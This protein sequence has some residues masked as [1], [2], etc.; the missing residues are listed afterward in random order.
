MNKTLFKFV[1]FVVT[2]LA[3]VLCLA[4]C[5]QAFSNG[6]QSHTH[7]YGKWSSDTA[8]CYEGGLKVRVCS[9]CDEVET[10]KTQPL[11]HDMQ[12]CDD[13][14]AGCLEGGYTNCKQCSRCE[15]FEGESTPPAGHD[16][17]E[18]SVTVEA[19]CESDGTATRTCNRCGEPET[20]KTN[21]LGHDMIKFE[22]VKVSCLEDGYSN[23]R[24]CSRCDHHEGTK[25]N[26]IGHDMSEWFGNTATCTKD[27]IEFSEC[28]RCDYDEERP[29]TAKGHI[30]EGDYCSRCQMDRILVLIENGVANFRVVHTANS[31]S[32]GAILADMFVERLRELGVTV[33]DSVLDVDNVGA[34]DCEIIIGAEAAGRGDECKITAHY[35][36]REGEVIKRVGNKIIIAATDSSMTQA[37][38][39]KFVSECLGITAQTTSLDYLEINETC[40]YENIIKFPISDIFINS[41][42]IDRYE[43]VLDLATDMHKDDFSAIYSF[44]D[45]LR[46]VSGYRL[47]SATALGMQSNKNYIV[48]RYTNDAGEDGFRVYVDGNKFVIECAYKNVFDATF[49]E[50]ANNYFLNA[51]GDINIDRDFRYAKTVSKVYYEDFGAVGDGE[52]CDFEAIYNAHVFANAGGQ[53][54]FGKKDAVYYISPDKFNKSIPIKTN[55]DFCGA[56]FIVND[57]GSSAYSSRSKPLF[58]IERDYEYRSVSTSDI[59]RLTGSN[60]ISIPE[61]TTSIK[62]LVPELE[63]KSM[64]EII[65]THRDYIRHGANQNNG[66]QRTDMVIINPDG[67][68]DENTYVAYDFESVTLIRIYR[69][70]ENPL[71]VENG[72]FKNICCKVIEDTY[73]DMPVKNEDGSEGTVRMY[74]ANKYHS[75]KRGFGIYRSNVTIKNITHEMLDE[76]DLGWYPEE[77]GYSPDAKYYDKY[78][79]IAYGS[80]HESY[81]YYGFLFVD[82]AYNLQVIDTVLDGH[83]TYYEDKPATLSTGNEIPEPVPMG[84]YDFVLEYSN[85]VTFKNVQQRDESGI[86][87]SRYWGIMSSNGSRNLTFENCKINRFDAHRGFWN[88]TLINTTIGHSFNVVGGGT[89]IADGV[90]KITGTTFI[91]L[92]GDYGATFKGDMILK[93]CVFENHPSYNTSK[94]SSYKD[95]QNNE[96]YIINSGFNVKNSGWSEKNI[97]GAYWLWDFGYTC[98]MPQNITLDNFTSCA[99]KKTYLFNDL[100]DII[101]E[102]TYTE[103]AEITKAT[104][105]YPYQITQNITY[106]G[107]NQFEMCKGTTKASSSEFGTFTYQKLNSIPV[108]KDVDKNGKCDVCDD[109]SIKD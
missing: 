69:V 64:L 24:E 35:L 75:Y 25:I 97:F 10:K 37:L 84:S 62:W 82:R 16:M 89:L 19:K 79:N 52:T 14:A 48:I 38:F 15:L 45:N 96:A 29:T 2:S 36:G 13:I 108:H 41:V 105:K 32:T 83:T 65:S 74:Y 34:F 81:P 20:K 78:G 71:T 6:I 66:N 55:V 43:L 76:P 18:W 50:F 67:T 80:R 92:R 7:E 53:K 86:G 72:N 1:I 59:E 42:S 85:Y 91:S 21:A 49:E 103:G 3:V 22:N 30:L 106:I 88:A 58:V 57:E 73:Y 99:N 31:E 68:L 94:G 60:T 70:D 8:T 95:T 47:K 90:T 93:N 44:A 109:H 11:G 12:D 46:A 56:T 100:P 101:F 87:D 27:G 23:Y 4:S 9:I 17:S 5:N 33:S 40:E 77:C 26:A 104:V 39:N 98:Y 54:V 61:G 63:A 102:K 51:V 28:L 107:M